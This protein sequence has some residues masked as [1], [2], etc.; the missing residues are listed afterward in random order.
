MAAHSSSQRT[1]ISLGEKNRVHVLPSTE[2]NTAFQ[3]FPSTKIVPLKPGEDC[4]MGIEMGDL[5]EENSHQE[6]FVF[7]T[8]TVSGIPEIK[9]NL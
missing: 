6:A 4:R 5:Y 7:H 2:Q 3:L 9:G 8:C 1:L